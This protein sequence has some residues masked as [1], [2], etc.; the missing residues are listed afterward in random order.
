V[1]GRPG[2]VGDLGMCRRSLYGNREISRSTKE[3]VRVLQWSASGR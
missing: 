3:T 1:P 2:V